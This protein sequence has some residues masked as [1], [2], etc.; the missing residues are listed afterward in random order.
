MLY[1]GHGGPVDAGAWD[2]QK[3]YIETFLGAV[4]AA[5]WSD[6]E[7]AKAAVVQAAHDYLPAEELSFLMELSVE[8]IAGMLGKLKPNPGTSGSPPMV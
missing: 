8:P 4:E 3:G 6:P 2:W 7:A 5:D 1:V